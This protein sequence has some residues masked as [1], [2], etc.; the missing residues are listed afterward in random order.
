MVSMPPISLSTDLGNEDFF[1]GAIKGSI[2]AINPEA[3][4]VD[5]THQIPK[6]DV[7][8]ASFTMAN[9]AETFPEDSIFVAVVDPGVGT[10][11]KCILLRTENGFDFIGPDNGVFTLAARKFG[12]EEVR[13]VAN[14]DIMR[15]E[16]SSTFHG[17][18]IMAPAA[19]HLSLGLKPSE[20]G[21][22][23]DGL[24]LLDIQEPEFT[25]GKIL[26][27]V[28]N[29]DHFGNLVTNIGEDMVRNLGKRG[30]LLKIRVNEHQF[31]ALL[32]ETFGE[33]KKGE[34]LCYIGS[35]GTLEVAKNQ[36]NLGLELNAERGDELNIKITQAK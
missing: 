16:V 5:I 29:I 27:Q 17:R 9:A 13:S 30:T 36:A 34:K 18:D 15:S 12:V 1:V 21:P 32:V 3:K 6:H 7:R 19:A 33:V 4:I 10:E 2:L 26:G 35:T 23:I 24:N 22:R 14:E 20:I 28:I 8:T 25:N 11:R 31:E